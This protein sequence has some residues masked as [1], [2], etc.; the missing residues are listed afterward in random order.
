MDDKRMRFP[1]QTPFE[2]RRQRDHRLALSRRAE[3]TELRKPDPAG[4]AYLKPSGELIL[5]FAA[6][7]RAPFAQV[8]DLLNLTPRG[9]KV[10]GFQA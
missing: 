2:T 8:C 6:F 1:A 5:E 4:V 3:T 7:R 9:V 10:V